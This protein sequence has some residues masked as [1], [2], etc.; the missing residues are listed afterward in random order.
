MSNLKLKQLTGHII[1]QLQWLTQKTKPLLGLDIGATAIKGLVLQPSDNGF[2]VIGAGI[3]FLPAGCLQNREIKNF[4][5]MALAIKKLK[6][7]LNAHNYQVATALAGSHVISK[8]V[9]VEPQ[10]SEFDLE[11]QILLE[12]DSF[13]PFPLEEVYLDF[14]TIGA[15]ATHQGKDDVL[16]TAAHRELVDGCCTLLR[17]EKLEPAIM[18][19]EYNALANV[20]QS[21]LEVRANTCD[22]NIHMGTEIMHICAL[23]DGELIYHKEHTFG[24]EGLLQDMM[25]VAGCE[26]SIALEQLNQHA[27]DEH[28][29]TVIYPLFVAQCVQHIHRALQQLKHTYDKHDSTRVWLSGGLAQLPDIAQL[30]GQD[31]GHQTYIFNP[32]Q[33]VPC[34]NDTIKQL[35]TKHG[36]QFTLAFGLS[37]RSINPCHR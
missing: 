28:W 10:L 14:E 12:V 35:L 22:V 4:D 24:L 27:F 31:L 32:L 34:A 21:H 5:A 20:L 16:L 36:S 6:R 15:S 30:L 2:V 18:D 29:H 37:A 19:I 11:E 23:V 26:R 25:A 33:D 7:Q 17:E 9:Q 8:T 3:E 1:V 13:L